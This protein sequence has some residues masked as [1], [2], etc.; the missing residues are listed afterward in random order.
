MAKKGRR[1]AG[2]KRDGVREWD[3]K[4][5]KWLVANELLML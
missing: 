3:G 5:G 4:N 2:R 1:G